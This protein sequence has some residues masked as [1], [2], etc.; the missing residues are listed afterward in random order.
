[1]LFG[2]PVVDVALGPFGAERRGRARGIIAIGDLALGWLAIGGAARGIVA[3]GGVSVGVFSVGGA[4]VGLLSAFGGLAVSLG[5][6]NGGISIGAISAGGL[7]VGLLAQGGFAAGMFARGG[8]AIGKAF[9]AGASHLRWLLG[10]FPPNRLDT[11][12][13]MLFTLLPALLCGVSICILAIG[14]CRWVTRFI[15][16]Q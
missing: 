7:A 9:P 13:P 6:A 14:R 3:I 12:R 16:K 2:L 11:L 5:I 10:N 4:A 8:L 15:E 1:M